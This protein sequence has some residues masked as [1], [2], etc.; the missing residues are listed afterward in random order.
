MARDETLIFHILK[1]LDSLHVQYFE[2]QTLLKTL[3]R[4][5]RGEFSGEAIRQHLEQMLTCS[6]LKR[7]GC[8]R[9][10]GVMRSTGQDT[11]IWTKRKT[12][13]HDPK[14]RQAG[15]IAHLPA[16]T[17]NLVFLA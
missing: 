9:M 10:H 4:R 14:A 12:A 2:E 11:T 6:L 15:Y 5:S 13:H 17:K 1:T 16:F 3:E 8:K 7:S